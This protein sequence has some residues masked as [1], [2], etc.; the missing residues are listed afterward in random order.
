MSSEHHGQSQE[1]SKSHFYERIFQTSQGAKGNPDPPCA[2]KPW[3]KRLR[4]HRFCMELDRSK[5]FSICVNCL[6]FT[7]ESAIQPALDGRDAGKDA[8]L[9]KTHFLNSLARTRTS[10]MHFPRNK[11]IKVYREKPRCKP[12]IGW[13]RGH[14]HCMHL[15][16]VLGLHAKREAEGGMAC[17]L[18]PRLGVNCVPRHRCCITFLFFGVHFT[19]H[20]PNV[21][22]WQCSVPLEPERE[23]ACVHGRRY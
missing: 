5:E 6:Q 19:T 15:L 1:F 12:A 9:F 11:K 13:K 14:A 17:A 3:I 2:R 8:A 22:F 4:I 7:V 18:H 16:C 23:R 21:F 20:V 10:Q